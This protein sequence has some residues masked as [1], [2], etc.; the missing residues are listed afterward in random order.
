MGGT[1]AK[2]GKKGC[3]ENIGSLGI[4]GCWL[5]VERLLKFPIG[6]SLAC[7]CSRIFSA[8]PGLPGQ[9]LLT[10]IIAGIASLRWQLFGD[11][12]LEEGQNPTG[13]W[14]PS[15]S[16]S[17]YRKLRFSLGQ[18]LPGVTKGIVMPMLGLTSFCLV[19]S[20]RGKQQSL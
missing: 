9:S 16:F 10:C 4:P 3:E 8:I 15:G 18:S 19:P 13:L 14:K 1:F 17:F 6:C 5:G 20:R 12:R 11:P 2:H 7:S